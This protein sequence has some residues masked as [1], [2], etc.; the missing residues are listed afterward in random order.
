MADNYT[1]KCF[2]VT[3]PGFEKDEFAYASAVAKSYRL[4]HCTTTIIEDEVAELMKMVMH[5]QEEPFSSASPLGQYKVF[6]LAKEN[7]VTVLLDGQGADE[8]LA[9]YFKYYKWYWQELYRNKQ[10]NSSAELKYA[11]SLGVTEP[12]NIKNKLA[13]LLPEFSAGILQTKKAKEAFQHAHLNRDFAFEN[14]R[15][16]NYTVPASHD[17][18]GALYHDTFING[19]EELLRLADRNSMA[20]S[21]EVRLPFLNYQL[22]EFL[23]T[24]PPHFKIHEGWTKWLLR[25]SV[26]D[27]LPKEITWRKNKV[28]FEPPQ[29]KWMINKAVQESIMEGKKKLVQ[30]H[31]LD[32]ITLKNLRPHNAYAAVNSDWKYWS[33]SFLF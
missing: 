23:F 20:H 7:G 1:H 28:G 21:T 25:K 31:I 24:L 29:K 26:D 6:Q 15:N 22:V 19:L 13:A 5:H 9:G 3:Y 10:L 8:I 11:R 2:T 12:F 17:L 16:L 18:N 30:A 14:K 27:K 32:P 33:A 4:Q